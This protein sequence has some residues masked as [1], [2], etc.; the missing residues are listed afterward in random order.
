MWEGGK[1]M[2]TFDSFLMSM[3][4]SGTPILF[5]LMGDLVGQQTGIISLSVEG[6]ML[7]GACAGF[8]VAA[9]TN[10]LILTILAAA[11]AGAFIGLIQAYLVISRKANM[12][13]SG[14][15]LIFFAQGITGFAGRNLLT[16]EIV[17]FDKI[18]VP[19]ISKI[20]VI[21][22]FFD[23]DPITYLSYFVIVILFLV[24]N[25]TRFGFE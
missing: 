12:L 16:K 17:G 15:T 25:K 6:S 5:A 2:Q 13:A 22:V 21:G 8:A 19:V 11:L 7:M 9:Y 18:A 23:Q 14:L 20:P 1:R 3:I 10:N 24:L 4:S